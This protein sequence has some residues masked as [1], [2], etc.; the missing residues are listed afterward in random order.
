VIRT[1]PLY[2]TD[3][4]RKP[5]DVENTDKILTGDENY[6]MAD[7]PED[8]DGDKDVKSAGVTRVVETR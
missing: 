6:A 4:I 1:V 3:D 5:A 8:R 7:A 2:R